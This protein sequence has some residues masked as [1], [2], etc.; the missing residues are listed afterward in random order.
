MLSKKWALFALIVLVGSIV[1]TACEG[2]TKEVEVTRVVT[3][4]ETVTVVEEKVETVVQT[5]VE[6]E[7]VTETVKETVTVV[8]EPTAPPEETGP[9]TLVICQGQEPDT[10]YTLGGSMLASSQVLQA[11]Y[12][13][14][15]GGGGIDS[16]SFAYQPII[17]EKLSS[18]PMA[19]PSSRR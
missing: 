14:F 13:G 4:K 2:E 9:R 16:R 12:D 7:T 3:E 6:K 15:G 8:V 1:L 10:L 5:V 17:L 18:L 19:M 11:V